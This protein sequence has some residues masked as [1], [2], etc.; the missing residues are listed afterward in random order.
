[1]GVTASTGARALLCCLVFSV[2]DNPAQGAAM[3]LLA[4]SWPISLSKASRGGRRTI[5]APPPSPHARHEGS[6]G[7]PQRHRQ[8]RWTRCLHRSTQR[9]PRGEP[10]E[11]EAR[12]E[13][14]SSPL[15]FSTGLATCHAFV[16]CSLVSAS[17]ITHLASAS[18]HRAWTYLHITRADRMPHPIIRSSQL[19]VSRTT[20]AHNRTRARSPPA[21]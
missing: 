14:V 11:A 17:A 19:S 21:L 1:M 12:A 7:A 18:E 9:R 5:S 8:S 6:S 4:K 13:R 10:G 16:S 15:S 3:E 2:H 20:C